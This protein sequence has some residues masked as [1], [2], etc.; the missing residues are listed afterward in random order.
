[1]P[2]ISR[3]IAARVCF[4]TLQ[5]DLYLQCIASLL[6]GKWKILA[7]FMSLFHEPRGMQEE[8]QSATLRAHSHGLRRHELH[9]CAAEQIASPV[10]W[11]LWNTSISR[12]NT[13]ILYTVKKD[14]TRNRLET[15]THYT[16]E[17]EKFGSGTKSTGCGTLDTIKNGVLQ[18]AHTACEKQHHNARCSTVT[19]SVIH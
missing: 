8:R 12:T 9:C 2:S 16:R 4:S 19:L 7:F 17:R 15:K 18:Y 13:P 3:S 10:R 14:E 5:S 1:M 6:T 11:A